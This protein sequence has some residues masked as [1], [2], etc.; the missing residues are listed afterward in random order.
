MSKNKQPKVK[1]QRLPKKLVPAMKVTLCPNMNM[2]PTS[3]RREIKVEYDEFFKALMNSAIFLM[4]HSSGVQMVKILKANNA[5]YNYACDTPSVLSCFLINAIIRVIRNETDG[6]FDDV[7]FKEKLTKFKGFDKK[8]DVYREFIQSN[9]ID[10]NDEQLSEYIALKAMRDTIAHSSWDNRAKDYLESIGYP[11]NINEFTSVHLKR[12]FKIGFE[13]INK[14]VTKDQSCEFKQS[15][16]NDINTLYKFSRPFTRE[17]GKYEVFIHHDNT[18]SLC[19]FWISLIVSRFEYN[20]SK[21]FV[22]NHEISSKLEGLMSGKKPNDE[23]LNILRKF[24]ESEQVVDDQIIKTNNFPIGE[25]LTNEMTVV[26]YLRNVINHSRWNDLD[27]ENAAK[28][29][30]PSNINEFK[31]H[32]LQKLKDFYIEFGNNFIKSIACDAIYDNIAFDPNMKIN[33]K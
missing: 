15:M 7:R 29:G 8:I 24:S 6:I 19:S 17:K 2:D 31:D 27:K 23:K 13:L 14:V 5:F 33:G 30:Y 4:A 22:V 12:L 18:S 1:K 32:H 10:W 11:T 26:I 20:T 21:S 28:F 9:N 3:P 25:N 16:I